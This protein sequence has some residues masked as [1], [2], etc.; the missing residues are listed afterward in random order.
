MKLCTRCKKT[1]IAT[2][3]VKYCTDCRHE[4]KLEKMHKQIAERKGVKIGGTVTKKI[5]KEFL[6]RGTISTGSMV[7]TF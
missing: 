3:Y 7:G 6:E 4:V 1:P 5:P 2:K